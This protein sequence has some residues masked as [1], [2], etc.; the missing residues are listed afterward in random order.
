MIKWT[1]P[2][3]IFSSEFFS[4]FIQSICVMAYLSCCLAHFIVHFILN[5][6]LSEPLNIIFKIFSTYSLPLHVSYQSL[7]HNSFFS[8]TPLLFNQ[9][10]SGC[11]SSTTS[12][13]FN[14]CI[15]LMQLHAWC[16]RIL[17][18]GLCIYN[19]SWVFCSLFSLPS[20]MLDFY[21]P[22]AYLSVKNYWTGLWLQRSFKAE[23]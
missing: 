5:I 23:W 20:Q 15:E 14:H 4:P 2:T 3:R 12:K 13:L 10:L 17:T 22:Y 19:F 1:I 18:S 8:L 6:F 21:I 9:N 11:H 16:I 7:I